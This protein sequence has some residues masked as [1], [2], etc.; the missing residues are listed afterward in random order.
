MTMAVALLGFA[1]AGCG[2]SQHVSALEV[3][4]EHERR[5]G[6]AVQDGVCGEYRPHVWE[7]T[8]R[9]TDGSRQRVAVAVSENGQHATVAPSHKTLARAGRPRPLRELGANASP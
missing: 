4:I 7:C 6:D 1:L 2:G 5:A 8:L 9:L 3:A